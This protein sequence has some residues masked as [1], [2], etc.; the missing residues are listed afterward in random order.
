MAGWIEIV[1]VA[2]GL[3]LLALP[4]EKGQFVVA[5]LATRYDPWRVVAGA[6][7]AFGCWTVVEIL[8]ADALR[9]AFPETAV[10]ATMGLLFLAVGAWYLLP[11]VSLPTTD[12]E[13]TL[14]SRIEGVSPP[15]YEGFAAAF[16]LFA[17]GEIGDKTQLITIA[18]AVRY[19]ADP[20][21]WLGVMAA[22]VPVTAVTAVASARLSDRVRPELV[23]R[24]AGAVFLAFGVDALAGAL[25]GRSLLPL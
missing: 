23:R 5:G 4:G 16:G 13:E 7:L 14:L 25:F 9:G 20:A 18:L 21:V 19:G 6:S 10:S 8:V 17:V 15:G 11:A 12:R 1:A 22:F 3:Q 2:A 24:I